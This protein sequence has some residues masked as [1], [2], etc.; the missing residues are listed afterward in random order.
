MIPRE[1]LKK[2]RQ[3]ETR[4]NRIVTDSAARGCPSRST[5]ATAKAF[6]SSCALRSIAA[7][8]GETPAL[9][10]LQPPPQFRRIPRAVPDGNHL[11]FT[12]LRVDGEINRVGPR[13]GHL[14]FSR[15]WRCQPKPI[16]FI[17]QSLEKSLKFVVESP[18]HA[19]LACLIP[20]HRLI[21][22]PLGFGFRNDFERHFLARRRFLISADTSSIGV[23][24]PGCVR[25][26]SA[27]RSSSAACSGVK[28]GSYPSS[29]RSS[30]SFRASSIRSASGRVFAALNNSVALMGINLSGLKRFASA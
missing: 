29:R 6:E 21:P 11:H 1:I 15:R 10:S 18:T 12:V 3:I 2:I 25:A 24:R 13:F 26:S 8:A 22:F 9:L 23:P 16:G 19:S 27:R 17:R 28:S 14:R 5:S 20:I 30:L 7:T 4:T